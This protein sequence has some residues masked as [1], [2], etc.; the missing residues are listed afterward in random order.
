MISSGLEIRPPPV[1]SIL[2]SANMVALWFT[3]LFFIG[4]RV[5]HISEF[6]SYSCAKFNILPLL[7][8]PAIPPIVKTLPS[9]KR[10]DRWPIRGGSGIS[11]PSFK[12]PLNGIAV[13]V[14]VTC[15]LDNFGIE[16]SMTIF[17]T[18]GIGVGVSVGVDVGIGVGV[19]VGIGVGIDVGVGV[20]I[21][22]GT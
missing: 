9:L 15:S 21:E 16:T 22:A 18:N 1:T 17:C 12:I 13:G 20:E 7:W 6:G 3:L 8:S 11:G 2:P 4:G 5:D 14:G 19:D 10:I